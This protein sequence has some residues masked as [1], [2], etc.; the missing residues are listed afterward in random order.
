[1]FQLMNISSSSLETRAAEIDERRPSVAA[2]WEAALALEP[3]TTWPSPPSSVSENIV[4]DKEPP[5]AWLVALGSCPAKHEWRDLG[6]F[7]W[8]RLVRRVECE[9]PA[10]FKPG[11]ASTTSCG[12]PPGRMT[13]ASGLTKTLQLLRW[14]CRYI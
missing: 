4:L 7:F 9:R 12:W 3:P 14:H 5:A 11:S 13:C 2:L 6:I 8:P 10:N 1:M